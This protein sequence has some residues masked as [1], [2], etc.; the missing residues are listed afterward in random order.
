MAKNET[1]SGLYLF[2]LFRFEV[3]LDW[4]W[5]FLAFL[6]MWTLAEGYFPINFKGLSYGTYWIMGLIGAIGLFFSIILHEVCHSLVGRHYGLPI[7][8]IKLFIFGGVAQMHSEPPSPKAEFLM[9]VAGPLFS[10]VIGVLLTFL[11]HFG[12]N[13]GWPTSIN[14]VISYLGFINIVVGIFNLLPGFPLDGGRI[15]RSF[16][17]WLKKDLRLATQIATQFGTGTSFALIMLGIL[18]FI[19]RDFIGGFW[20]FLLGFFL[21]QIS[22]AQYQQFLIKEIFHGETI[23]KYVHTHPVTVPPNITVQEL[24]DDY[25]YKYYHKL[26]PVAQDGNLLG[27]VTLNLIKHIPK[28]KWHELRVADIIKHCPEEIIIDVNT[29][30]T[31]ILQKVG[32]LRRTR[33]IVIENDKLYGIITLKDIVNIVT[34]KTTFEE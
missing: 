23:R 12:E 7:L 16:L 3:R 2:S 4:S 30:V 19:S 14:G 1:K 21:Y 28:E 31:D 17:W 5:F 32:S 20:M 9:A 11:Y 27:C 6:V 8:G 33:F 29:K 34:I 10:I 22:K 15:L 13:A 25:F 24:I 26:Y 18:L